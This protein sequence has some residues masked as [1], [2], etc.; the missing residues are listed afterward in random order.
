[1]KTNEKNS[2]NTANTKPEE[3][4]APKA[5]HEPQIRTGVKAGIRVEAGGAN[6]NESVTDEAQEEQDRKE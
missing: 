5:A 6:H 1:M 4:A 2:P 3:K